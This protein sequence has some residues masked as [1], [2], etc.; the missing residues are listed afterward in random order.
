MIALVTGAAGFV[1]SHLVERL[2]AQGAS[3]VAVDNL[4]TG[5]LAH[6]ERVIASGRAVFVLGDVAVSPAHL[7][8]LLHD[9]RV[10]RIDEIYHL[11]SPASPEAYGRHPWETLAVNALGT[12]ATLDVAR[13]FGARYLFSS[14][15]EVY[16]DPLVH[17]QPEDYFGNVNPVGPRAC[18]DE[19]KRFGEAAV[20]VAATTLGVDARI[21]RI[22]NCYGPRMD[23]GDGRLI[24]ALMS[25]ALDGKP[26]PIHGDGSQTR[27]LTYVDDLVDGIVRVMRAPGA[28]HAPVNLGADDERAVLEIAQALARVAGV[29]CT[30]ESLPARPEDPSRRRPVTARA[31]ALGWRAST[32]LDDGLRATYRWFAEWS[33]YGVARASVPSS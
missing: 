15:S 3:V 14:T 31:A 10:E 28:T 19:G 29:P 7:R 12:M 13:A 33:G 21:V 30:I 16:G 6:L 1:G 24:P 32:S 8:T 20:S 18:Y 11:A 26:F 23:P 5:K 17:P 9:A 2:A 27:S 25:A 22:F 4:L